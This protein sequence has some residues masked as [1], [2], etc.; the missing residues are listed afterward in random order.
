MAMIMHLHPEDIALLPQGGGWLMVE[1]GGDT[2]RVADERARGLMEE[3][4]RQPNPPTMKLF[5]DPYEEHRVWLVRES[6]LGATTFLPGPEHKIAWPG[7]EDSAVPPDR[8]GDYLRDFRRLLD[9]YGY[10]GSLYG[11]FGQGCLHTSTNFD[12]ETRDG[13]KAFRSF[14][15]EAADLVVRYGGSLSG[16]HGDG[17]ARGELLEKMFGAELVQ[18]FREFKAIWDP[19]GRMNPGKIVDA[20]RLD[21]NLRLGTEYGPPR[22]R[23]HFTFPQDEGSFARA[24]LRCVGVGEC[25]KVDSGTMC[26]SYMVTREEMHSTR[27]RARMLFEMLQGDPLEGGWRDEHVKEALDL[28]LSCKGCKGECPVSV[29]MATY[30]AEFLSH[31]FAGRPRPVHAYAFGLIMYWA[32]FAAVAPGVANFFTQT[33]LLADLAK[34]AVGMAPQ[35]QIPAFAPQ[36]FKEWFRHRGPRNVGM[37]QVMLWPDTFNNH[38]HPATAMAAVEILEAAG[39]QVVVPEPFLCCG[40]PLYD[41]G[42]LGL[43]KRH[44]RRI[45]ETLRPRIREGLPVVG[46]EPS[47]VAVFRDELLNLF[48]HDEDAK[49]LH[50]QALLLSE[51]LEQ[52]AGAYRLPRLR[53]KALVHGHCHHKAIMKMRDEERVLSR[54]GLDFEVL[55]SGCCGMAGAFGFEKGDHFEVSIRAGERVLLPTVRK[56]GTETLIIADGFSCREQIA[57]TTDRHALHLAQVIQ[58]ALHEG[59]GGPAVTYTEAGQLRLRDGR[60]ERAGT[61][62]R[63]AALAG[64]GALLA[65]GALLLRGRRR[66]R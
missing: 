22:H 54:L 33:P 60:A 25:R 31:Y 64:T 45:L 40:R 7:W 5:D 50:R 53:R 15:E 46:L 35:R 11:H 17:Q 39:Y 9:R 51:F 24:S 44:L 52:K 28:C 2:K 42:M 14:V 19:D 3:L 4:R 47:C 56:A 26:P 29:D 57:Q 23:T 55:D 58:M 34:A 49:R 66:R 30:K 18:A 6:G 8:L 59:S 36:T 10:D 65:G 41:Y 16:E 61:V 63:I 13:I 38:F 20:Y 32:R 21:E 62:W 37:P 12:L 27:G 1:F 48:P 43:A